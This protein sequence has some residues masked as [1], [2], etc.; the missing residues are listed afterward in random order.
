MDKADEY[1]STH[2]KGAFEK[3]LKG[4]ENLCQNGLIG[5]NTKTIESDNTGVYIEYSYYWTNLGNDVLRFLQIIDEKELID[6]RSKI[7]ES[8]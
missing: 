4:L 6:R 3:H 1:E 5:L 7:P 2:G 8:F